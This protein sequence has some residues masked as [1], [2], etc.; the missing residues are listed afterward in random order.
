M[1][2]PSADAGHSGA[3]DSTCRGKVDSC[4]SSSLR[5]ERS[6][7]EVP[8]TSRTLA[9]EERKRPTRALPLSP[10]LGAPGSHSPTRNEVHPRQAS[11]GAWTSL[12]PA[13]VP[14]TAG[15]RHGEANVP[16]PQTLRV[17]GGAA[18]R[19]RRALP[20]G[21]ALAQ[22]PHRRG[23]HAGL[24]EP[25]GPATCRMVAWRLRAMGLERGDRLLTW[26]PSTPELPAVYWGAMMAGVIIVP[27]DLRMA[28][29]VL[30][31]IA[32]QAEARWLAIGTRAGCARPRRGRTGPPVA[33]HHRGARGGAGRR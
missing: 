19:C 29:A 1:P 3:H 11:P 24:V 8:T 17:V 33:R 5:S 26:S 18:R 32:D 31:R 6:T 28:P 21:P 15:V 13:S 27:L 12:G 7:G 9:D 30:R 16:R 14:T 10:H 23:H 22:P 25:R 2:S 20:G 4:P